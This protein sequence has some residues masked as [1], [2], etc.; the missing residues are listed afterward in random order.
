M[1]SYTTGKSLL[2]EV[3]RKNPIKKI[4]PFRML[5]TTKHSGEE[6]HFLSGRSFRINEVSRKNFKTG[7][8]IN[9]IEKI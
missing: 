3:K 8:G 1:A 2:S 6:P 9:F 4:I 5:R 7:N